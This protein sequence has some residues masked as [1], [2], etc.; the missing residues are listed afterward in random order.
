MS[1]CSRTDRNVCAT[2]KALSVPP[3]RHCLCH[4][5]GTVCVSNQGHGAIHGLFAF[6][7]SGAMTWLH[8]ETIMKPLL[9]LFALALGSLSLNFCLAGESPSVG[10][11]KKT[12]DTVAS[13]AA[14]FLRSAQ[15]KN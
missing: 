3:T 4:Q 11:D 12:W 1:V 9:A 8:Q 6:P 14:R 15:D 10:P 13:K 5:Q 2:S 7:L